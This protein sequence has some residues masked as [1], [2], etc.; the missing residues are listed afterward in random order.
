[1]PEESQGL[2]AVVE[3]ADKLV[4]FL[5]YQASIPSSHQRP[6]HG[7]LSKA[8]AAW[9]CYPMLVQFHVRLLQRTLL[10]VASWL[11]NKR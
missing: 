10:A 5:Q 8:N 6:A 3:V 1:V 9:H 2:V 7:D 11:G 4:G